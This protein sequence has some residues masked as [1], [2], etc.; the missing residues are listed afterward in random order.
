[1]T[2]TAVFVIYSTRTSV[3][4]VSYPLFTVSMTNLPV[5]SLKF[6]SSGKVT[7][8]AKCTTPWNMLARCLGL[9]FRSMSI[10]RVIRVITSRISEQY[11]APY[12]HVRPQPF[13]LCGEKQRFSSTPSMPP[14]MRAT[15]AAVSTPYEKWNT[16]CI[17]LNETLCSAGCYGEQRYRKKAPTDMHISFRAVSD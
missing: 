9:P 4:E 13:A 6:S 10:G 16:W 17:G 11:P 7:N 1:M 15:T 14:P 8:V 3:V 2:G 12:R 5:I